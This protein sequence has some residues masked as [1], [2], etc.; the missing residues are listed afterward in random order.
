ML[1]VRAYPP[2]HE[3]LVTIAHTAAS[4]CALDVACHS[5][6]EK[7]RLTCFDQTVRKGE[8]TKRLTICRSASADWLVGLSALLAL[9]KVTFAVLALCFRGRRS[10][11]DDVCLFFSNVYRCEGRNVISTYLC[12]IFAL[13]AVIG[14][15]V[16]SPE[17]VSFSFQRKTLGIEGHALLS[18]LIDVLLNGG[19]G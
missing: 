10:V 5:K 15:H 1:A 18:E 4:W 13:Q 12:L 8:K 6:G 19:A 2:E 16:L 3:T 17:T 9:D 7:N 11:C 14:Q